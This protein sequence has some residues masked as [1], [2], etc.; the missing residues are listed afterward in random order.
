MA[1]PVNQGALQEWS[2]DP[3][4]IT[5]ATSYASKSLGNSDNSEAD[6]RHMGTLRTP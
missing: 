1:A 4:S 2:T 5:I 6:M 3:E